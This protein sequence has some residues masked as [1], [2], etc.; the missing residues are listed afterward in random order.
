MEGLPSTYPSV[1]LRSSRGFQ[2]C[3]NL[4]PGECCRKLLS[5]EDNDDFEP[6]LS[7]TPWSHFHEDG[8]FEDANWTDLHTTDYAFL[9][10]RTEMLGHCSGSEVAS[11]RG[12]ISRD[13][14]STQPAPLE[15][16]GAYYLRLN[17]FGA[18]NLT[19]FALRA[20]VNA[21]IGGR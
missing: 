18:D 8:F 14:P 15:I 7:D 17:G 2:A 6:L 20:G 11:M 1:T 12:V 3:D 4:C 16:S 21:R 10:S 5:D 13:Y 9:W 19:D